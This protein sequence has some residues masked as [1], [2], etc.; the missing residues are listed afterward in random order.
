MK[1]HLEEA[2]TNTQL[3]GKEHES[4]SDKQCQAQGVFEIYWVN[5]RSGV[6]GAELSI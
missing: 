6:D 5:R 2:E 3:G 4:V 1:D